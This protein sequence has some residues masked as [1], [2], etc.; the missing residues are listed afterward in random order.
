MIKIIQDRVFSAFRARA[1]FLLFPA[2]AGCPHDPGSAGA[3]GGSIVY[4]VAGAEDDGVIDIIVSGTAG[5]E[6]AA[7]TPGPGDGFVITVNGAELCRG[8]LVVSGGRWIFTDSEGREILTILRLEDGTLVIIS[9]DI[10]GAAGAPYIYP[11]PADGPVSGVSGVTIDQEGVLLSPG[12][13]AAFSATV[14][15]AQGVRQEVAWAVRNNRSAGTAFSGGILTVAADETFDSPLTVLAISQADRSK[16]GAAAVGLLDVTVSPGTASV[17]QGGARTFSAKVTGTNDPAQEVVWSLAAPGGN[18]GTI[19][20]EEGTLIVAAGETAGELTVKAACT[21]A[22]AKYG[23]AAVTV[24]N[25]LAA[26]TGV[27]VSPRT[28][29]VALGGTRTFSAEISGTGNPDPRVKWKIDG[30]DVKE[31]T[32]ISDGGVLVVA[33]DETAGQFTV[34]A[35]SVLNTGKDNTAAVT[36]SQVHATVDSVTVSPASAVVEQG[37]SLVFSAASAGSH[38]PQQNVTWTIEESGRK[39]GT[40]ISADGR[41]TVDWDEVLAVLTV[42]AVSALNP[43]KS[44]TA[45]VTVKQVPAAITG[46]TVSPA[47]ADVAAG[48]TRTFSATVTGTGR[49]APDVVW[50]VTESGKKDGTDI[51][52]KGKLIVSQDEELTTLTVK[53]T[54]VDNRNKSGT[55]TVTVTRN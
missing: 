34:R 26:V 52:A 48:S 3:G 9:D 4:C 39:A 46:V 42:K 14:D 15:G 10:P 19:I 11:K 8:T 47:S 1:V 32:V 37:A 23:T 50:S 2:L 40:V 41:L 13:S 54:A 22:P 49:F 25:S 53:A 51:T 45:A 17:A 21:A 16:F 5:E 7:Y 29:E 12:G 35:V 30:A 24:I 44:G 31:G 55:A 33:A 27:T 28:A 18:E 36:V 20:T 38:S 6:G 43:G